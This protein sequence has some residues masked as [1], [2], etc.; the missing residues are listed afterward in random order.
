MRALLP[1]TLG[2]AAVVS[3]TRVDDWDALHA[4]LS[5]CLVS[6][7][8]CTGA[9]MGIL[10]ASQCAQQSGQWRPAYGDGAALQR[11][12][13]ATST[14]GAGGVAH[15]VQTREGVSVDADKLREWGASAGVRFEHY[16]NCAHNARPLM[17]MLAD[18]AQARAVQALVVD[19]A[20]VFS[21]VFPLPAQLK[22]SPDT[23][24]P[25]KGARDARS[26]ELEVGVLGGG[27]QSRVMSGLRSRLAGVSNATMELIPAASL[28]SLKGVELAQVDGVRRV[29]LDHASAWW[30]ERR[31]PVEMMNYDAAHILQSGKVVPPNAGWDAVPANTPFWAVGMEGGACGTRGGR[32]R[33]LTRSRPGTG[34][35]HGGQRPGLQVV[36]LQLHP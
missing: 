8:Q 3:A 18:E 17:Y 26:V 30:V 32:G 5:D 4:D 11:D 29:L 27:A 9:G 6:M 25:P 10:S 16:I 22:A 15:M 35:G 24:L 20:P 7:G 19:G 23:L 13:Q 33:V 1:A 36:L 34:R 2:L 31:A 28:V 12:V 14:A 21:A